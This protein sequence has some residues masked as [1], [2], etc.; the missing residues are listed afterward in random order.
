LARIFL[1]SIKQFFWD[2]GGG[3][4]AKGLLPV[5]RRDSEDE[6]CAVFP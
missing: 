4:V 5:R 2:R 6:G 3:T 1:H